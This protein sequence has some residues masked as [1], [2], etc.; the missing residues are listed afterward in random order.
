M[1]RDKRRR[2]LLTSLGA[3]GMLFAS[4]PAMAAEFHA[5]LNGSK[6]PSGG[7]ADGWGRVKFHVDD[8]LNRLCA[9]FEVRAVGKVTGVDIY[10]G[11]PGDTSSPVVRLDTPDDDRDSTDCDKIGDSLADEIQADPSNFYVHVRTI[12]YPRGA[13]AGQLAPGEGVG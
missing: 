4:G 11:E 8:S 6:L 3:L 9:D 10:R 1:L 5:I 7:D 13:L 12:E 2:M